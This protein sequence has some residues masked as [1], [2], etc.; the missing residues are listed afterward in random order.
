MNNFLENLGVELSILEQ[1]RMLSLFNTEQIRNSDIDKLLKILIDES[2]WIARQAGTFQDIFMVCESEKLVMIFP[3]E[4]LEQQPVQKW[5]PAME[6]LISFQ[7]PFRDLFTALI[8]AAE[9]YNCVSGGKHLHLFYLLAIRGKGRRVGIACMEGCENE[10]NKDFNKLQNLSIQKL[11]IVNPA[12][13]LPNN[14]PKVLMGMLD[15]LEPDEGIW[16]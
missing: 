7:W 14:S 2:I 3:E 10:L 13:M 5:L 11:E 16:N 8:P 9:Y 15:L 12:K 6:K 4:F 1:P